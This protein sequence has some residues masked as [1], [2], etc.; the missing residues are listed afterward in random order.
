MRCPV[1]PPDEAKRLAALRSYGFADERPLPDLEPVVRIAARMFGTKAAIVNMIGHDHV[2]FAASTGVGKV[3]MGRDVS[4]CAHAILQ[5]EV[6]V[7]PDARA[8]ARFHDNPLVAC[9]DGIRFYAG[10]P[11]RSLDGHALGVLC[12]IDSKAR[13][14]FSAEDAARLVELARMAEDRLELR[15]I[16]VCASKA[17]VPANGPDPAADDPHRAAGLDPLT[18]LDDRA[19]FYRKVERALLNGTGA[20]VILLDLDAFKDIN[21]ILGPGPG[22]EMLRLTALRLRD[23]AGAEALAVARLGGDEFAVLAS[24]AQEAA[25][26]ELAARLQDA[27][28]AAVPLA[29]QEVRVTASCGVALSPAHAHEP[30]ALIG[31][32]DLALNQAKSRGDGARAVYA[33]ALRS[34]AMER[35]VYCLDLHRASARGE[36]VLFYQ[37]QVSLSDG[38]PT[39]A[40]ALIRW[41]HP[42]RGLLTPAAFLQQ[43]EKGRLVDA[44][45]PW[46]IDE[47]CAQAARWQ[48]GGATDFRMAVNIFGAQFHSGDLVRDVTQALARHGLAAEALELELTENIVLSGEAEV[49]EALHRLRAMGV[50]LAFD[51][52]GT[53]YASLSMLTQYPLTRIKIDRSF[54]GR[55]LQSPR[56]AAITGAIIRMGRD[57]GIAIT[58][59]GI[60]TAPQRDYL[61]SCG[62]VEGQGYLFG[63]PMPAAAF[64]AEFALRPLAERQA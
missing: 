35:R 23:A 8:D 22:D 57:L 29:G 55:M 27:V 26:L 18:G 32:A 43:L 53:G 56:E 48:R 36:F 54:V 59:E 61:V 64:E 24:L 15:R 60:E 42:T 31:N 13:P 21:N 62:C 7:V 6:M 33:P 38:A 44:V 10:I 16:D 63:K 30:V 14:A 2:F 41:L 28:A 47:A 51:D 46:V 19:Q 5:N 20:A 11:L 1:P 45:G 40:E 49:L 34:A 25:A 3:D 12:V 39:G 17:P 52:F 37:P 50:G 9:Q 58:A 4:F